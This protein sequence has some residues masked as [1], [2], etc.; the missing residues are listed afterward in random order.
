[1]KLKYLYLVI[2]AISFMACDS[3]L[4]V[5]PDER[6]TLDSPEKVSELLVNAYCH[7]SYGMMCFSM[8]DNAE[9]KGSGVILQTNS[10][11][12]VW[13]KIDNIQQDSPTAYWNSCY[14]AIANTNE[15]LEFIKSKITKNAKGEEIISPEY[16]PY[17]GEALVARAYAHFMLVNLWSKTYDP[18]TAASDMGIPYVTKPEKTVLVDYKRGT[19]ASVYAN[20]EKD[21]QEGLP[22]INDGA[23]EVAKYHFNT[24]AANAFAS[25]FYLMKADWEK[26]IE[27]SSLV[28]GTDPSS[29][30]RDLN[31]RYTKMSL[32][33]T[34]VQYNKADEPS[35]LL[36]ASTASNWFNNY[37]AITRYT[38]TSRIHNLLF[39]QRVFVGGSW[40]LSSAAYGTV[41]KLMLKWSYLFK[42]QNMNANVGLY[43]V[44]TPLFSTEE[45]LFNRAEAYAMLNQKANAIADVNF[46]LS[47]KIKNYNSARHIATA[48]KI[49]LA[50]KESKVEFKL[51]PFYNATIQ[52]RDLLNCIIDLKRKEFYYEGHRWFD[53][54]RFNMAVEHKVV[55]SNSVKLLEK[56][57]RKQLQIPESAQSYGI[58]LNPR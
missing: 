11:A 56:D 54:R 44:M 52:L 1:M 26:V 55:N 6:T 53:I 17:Y 5:T 32:N 12:Y 33:E 50:Y 23:Y 38:M 18:A 35:V 45:V 19:V 47:K 22:Y 36:L 21:L 25:R 2:A 24:D 3:Y 9:D 31:G 46:M 27:Y 48:E 41:N 39:T 7:H 14:K 51:N 10:D 49:N 34:V 57:L 42:R 8:S 30:L 13:D 4:D 43:Y 40:A 28:L 16:A 58:T 29:K 20:I 15:A 37:F